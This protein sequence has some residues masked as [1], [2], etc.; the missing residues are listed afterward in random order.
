MR[1]MKRIRAEKITGEFILLAGTWLIL[2]LPAQADMVIVPAGKFMMGCSI[3]DA[4]CEKDEGSQGG[5]A[6]TV[7]EF[8]ID[9]TEQK[10]NAR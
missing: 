1:F 5:T 8:S 6:V 3:N 4:D 7:P 2:M 9:T 10:Y